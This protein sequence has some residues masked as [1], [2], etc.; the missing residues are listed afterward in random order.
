M[1]TYVT[2]KFNGIIIFSFLTHGG[3]ISNSNCGCNTV[4]VNNNVY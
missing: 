3:A 2:Y 1:W 4:G